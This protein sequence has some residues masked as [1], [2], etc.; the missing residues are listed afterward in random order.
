MHAQLF[1][2]AVALMSGSAL[3][4]TNDL[5]DMLERNAASAGHGRLCNED[6]LSEQL[7]SATML[8]LA[9]SGVPSENVQLGSAKFSD[10]MRKEM[11]ERRK[12]RDFQCKAHIPVAEERLARAHHRARTLREAGVSVPAK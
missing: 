8:V 6:P 2:A 10:L 1:L 7:K 5:N 9:L 11:Q 3:A 4:D 12:D